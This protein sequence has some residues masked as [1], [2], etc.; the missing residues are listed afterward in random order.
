MD[1]RRV[2]FELWQVTAG[3]IFDNVL[4]TDDAAYAARFAEETW[5]ASKEGERAMYEAHAAALAGAVSAVLALRA[6][7]SCWLQRWGFAA[8]A[9]GAAAGAN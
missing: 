8:V 2:G 4:V 3:T 7:G 9:A 5:G 1:L 6:Y